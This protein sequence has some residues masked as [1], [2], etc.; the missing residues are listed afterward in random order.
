[1][2][3]VAS[4]ITSLTTVCPTVYSGA[5]KRKHQ[6]SA[7]LVFVQGTD[8]WPVNSP[9]K[10]PVTRNI[11][12]FDDV[13]MIIMYFDTVRLVDGTVYSEGRVEI[14][15]NGEWG[16]VCDD[17]WDNLDAQVV[18]RMLGHSGG[19][20]FHR[21]EFGQGSGSIWLDDLRCLG[22][23]DE[24]G[25]C[26]NPNGCWGCQNCRHSEDAGVRCIGEYWNW[27]DTLM[28]EWTW[29]LMVDDTLKTSLREKVSLLHQNLT[30]RQ[31]SNMSRTKSQKR[32]CFSPRLA[33]VFAQ[34]FEARSRM[35]MSRVGASSTGDAPT[36][37][38]WF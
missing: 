37:S 23:E 32:K 15:Y 26:Y 34:S 2:S 17:G 13:I 22:S 5:D 31:S 35:K 7:S 11:F 24:L 27:M 8:R 18:C 20:A 9:H 1:M 28:S 10:W 36:T 12:P 4:Q 14:L 3:T 21:A 6:S 25:D 16:T 30:C 29:T 38:E 19:T 33:V